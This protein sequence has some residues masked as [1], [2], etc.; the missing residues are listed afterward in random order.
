MNEL[1]QL[2]EALANSHKHQLSW[3]FVRVYLWN[4]GRGETVAKAIAKAN[5]QWAIPAAKE[6]PAGFFAGLLGSRPSQ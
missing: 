2:E 4:R 5:E 3:A 1:N 6:L